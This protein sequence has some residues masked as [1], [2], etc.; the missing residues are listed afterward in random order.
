[1][2]TRYLPLRLS[3]FANA[4][5][6]ALAVVGVSV[7]VGCSG[8]IQSATNVTQSSATVNARFACEAGQ[9]G[10]YWLEHRRV[11]A[12]GS[13]T[14]VGRR[15]L[16]CVT[17]TSGQRAY[18]L[19]GLSAG[20]PYEARMCA[21]WAGSTSAVCTDADGTVHSASD[22]GGT[23]SAR[24]YFRFTTT[25]APTG[26][27]ALRQVDGGPGYYGQFPN[28]L[29]TDASYFPIGVW[30]SYNHTQANR[31]L[32][33]AAG[34]NLY[35]WA[36][37]AGFID[38]IRADGRFRVVYDN[39]MNHS[40]VGSET[41]GW[42]LDD[43][44]DMREGPS[45]CPARIDRVKASLPNDGRFRYAN[46]GKGV[47]FPGWNWTLTDDEAA[48]FVNAQDITSNDIY[49]MSDRNTCAS[50]EGG[51]LFALGRTLT[52]AE[53]HRASN[54]GAVVDRMRALDVRNGSSRQPIWNFVEARGVDPSVGG[55]MVA[56]A[57][58]RAGVW[59]SIIAGARGILYFQHSFD[60]PCQGDHHV[61]RTN[62]QGTRPIVVSTNSQIKSLAP[63]LNAPF[64]DGL[65]ESSPGVRTMAK[66]QGGKLWVFAGRR[67][68]GGSTQNTISMPCVGNG[69]ATVDGEAR[70][71]PVENGQLTDTFADGNA[72][73]IYR[74]DGGSTCGLQ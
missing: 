61:I 66:W 15:T 63:V 20:T 58:I 72:V 30:G 48:C 27:V 37:D 18:Q 3:P 35:V 38:D 33:A 39:G 26:T 8:Q 29:P 10:E 68:N 22:D 57:E 6:A 50:F 41:A 16:N 17:A 5:L 56:P 44:L 31:D 64:A 62:C 25:A 52:T 24:N 32:D 53:C 7:L 42:L 14:E 23:L 11:G 1:V 12:T 54:Y 28:A 67:E 43:E 46:Y 74:I 40:V 73:H 65:V 21:G 55:R 70:M 51:S 60:G 71:V 4:R 69:T 59:H 2:P 47:I 34:I 45:A 19:T 13:W 36:A 49:W 9:A